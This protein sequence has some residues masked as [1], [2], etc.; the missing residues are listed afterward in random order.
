MKL[1]K[2]TPVRADVDPWNGCD[3]TAGLVV[4]AE[5]EMAARRLARSSRAVCS[6]DGDLGCGC[7]YCDPSRD[8]WLD[9]EKTFCERL[10]VSG[11]AEV[12][13]VDYKAG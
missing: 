1:W 2:L 10:P 5:S 12:I 8:L 3:L 4:R 6:H 7:Y 11:P 13:L 9:P